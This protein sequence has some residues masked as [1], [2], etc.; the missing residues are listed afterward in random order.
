LQIESAA[1]YWKTLKGV[2][3]YQKSKFDMLTL[4][5]LEMEPYY[6]AKCPSCDNIAVVYTEPICEFNPYLKEDIQVG[7]D[8]FQLECHYCKLCVDDYNALD[9]LK[10]EPSVHNKEE[11]IAGLK[12]KQ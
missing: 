4:E 2:A 8:V 9:F 7:L 1:N 3:T 5:L 11:V 10:I 12:L 6:P